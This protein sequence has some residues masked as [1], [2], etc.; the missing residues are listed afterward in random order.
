MAPTSG[1]ALNAGSGGTAPA[2]AAGSVLDALDALDV[3]DVVDEV[4]S[5]AFDVAGA[6]LLAL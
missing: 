5:G 1:D 3:V 2:C 6:A 4:V